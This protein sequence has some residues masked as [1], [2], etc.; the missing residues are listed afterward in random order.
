MQ[1]LVHATGGPGFAS[2]EETLAILEQGILPTFEAL[3]DLE[4]K[5]SI[6]A[7]GLPAGDRAFVF[8]AEAD[9]NDAVDRLVRDL[10]AWGVLDWAI[11]PL[12]TFAGRAAIERAVVERLS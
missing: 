12:Q 2:P 1:Y 8:I 9:D 7:G 3:L 4:R 5:G 10:P 6:V 11:T